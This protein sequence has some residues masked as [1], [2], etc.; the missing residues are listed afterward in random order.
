MRTLGG[1]LR[2]IGA[3]WGCSEYRVRRRQRGHETLLRLL[4]LPVSN[5]PVL[6]GVSLGV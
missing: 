6:H 3:V 4:A 5:E 2:G 1:R